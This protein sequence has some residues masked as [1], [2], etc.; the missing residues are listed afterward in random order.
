MASQEYASSPA[1]R[2]GGGLVDN[3]ME[4]Y[5]MQNI[6]APTRVGVVSEREYIPMGP[7]QHKSAMLTPAPD[8][9]GASREMLIEM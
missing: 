7:A 2:T 9:T 3:Q 1:R 8:A 4:D 5:L 6:N